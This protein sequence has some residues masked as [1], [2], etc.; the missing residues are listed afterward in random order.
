MLKAVYP[1]KILQF[2][3]K[4]K[5]KKR[6]RFSTNGIDKKTEGCSLTPGILTKKEYYRGNSFLF[7][8]FMVFY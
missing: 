2:R 6:L 8:S 5:L 4:C 3:S 1:I 7:T